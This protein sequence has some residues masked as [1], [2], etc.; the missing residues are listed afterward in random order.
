MTGTSVLPPS[1]TRPTR[2][3]AF[4]TSEN[5]IAQNGQQLRAHEL[6]LRPD[7]ALM[8]EGAGA[9]AF[10]RRSS[11]PTSKASERFSGHGSAI[12]QGYNH[13]ILPLANR[14]DKVTQ[15]KWGIADF[16][17]RFGR[18]PEGMWLPE[19]AVDT[20]TLEVLAENG[21]QFTI[22]APRQAKRVRS[23]EQSQM[24]RC[25]WRRIDPARALPCAV[26]IQEENQPVLLRWTDF[27][28]RGVRRIAE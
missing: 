15:V 19:T 14:R 28:R 6:Q 12:A 1:A 26:A 11:M 20:E 13:M 10:I 24:R 4:S 22:L 25:K 3:R 8:D 16:E 23:K 7:A 18:Q 27:A 9:R 5:R 21:I 17:S 2:P